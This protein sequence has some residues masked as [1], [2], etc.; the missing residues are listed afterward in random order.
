MNSGTSCTTRETLA[1][2]HSRRSHELKWVNIRLTQGSSTHHHMNPHIIGKHR[3]VNWIFAV[4]D[5]IEFKEIYILTPARIEPYFKK[6]AKEWS[7]DSDKDINNPKIP[8]KLV[9]ETGECV[10]TASETG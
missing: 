6:W 8:L 4:Y 10:Y 7:D 1:K 3:Q 2:P 9:R 5:G